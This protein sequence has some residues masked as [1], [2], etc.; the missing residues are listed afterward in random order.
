MPNST[1][2]W[3]N[4]LQS[5]NGF[6]IHIV[7]HNTQDL[8]SLVEST[9][10][11]N[12]AIFCIDGEK[13]NSKESLLGSIARS[14]RFPSYFGKNW[15]ALEDSIN[16]LSWWKVKGFL[17]IFEQAD[18]FIN[19]SIDEFFVFIEIISNTIK[20]WYVRGLPFYGVITI[21]DDFAEKKSLIWG[22]NDLCY[23]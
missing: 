11:L 12:F 10:P 8:T 22:N 2:W 6:L 4:H 14:M 1:L 15:D 13:I 21:S 18:S 7:P 9:R 16:D 23:H 20:S 5:P 19:S 17:L 3:G